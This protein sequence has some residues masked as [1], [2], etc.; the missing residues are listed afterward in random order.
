MER[1]H[2]FDF[3]RGIAI[4][5]VIGIHTCGKCGLEN[6]QEVSSL[7]AR[8]IIN[9]AVPLFLTLSGFLL[10]R[11]S[12]N[13]HEDCIRF[14]KKQIPKVYIPCLIWSLPLFIV[15]LINGRSL[16]RQ[17]FLLFSGGYSIYYFIPLIIQCYLLLPL[18]KRLSNVVLGVGSF[19]IT[20]CSAILISYH[21]GYEYPFLV[22]M[23]PI[24]TW[25]L[26][27]ALGI[28][29]CRSERN[30]RLS[31]LVMWII[32]SIVL[33]IVESLF[34]KNIGVPCPYDS[35]KPSSILYAA[36]LIILLFSKR[37]ELYYV[38]HRVKLIEYIGEISFTLYLGH[39]Y[40]IMV[41]SS[42]NLTIPFAVKWSTVLL[43]GT[44]CVYFL[45][46]L[47]VNKTLRYILGL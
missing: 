26:F 38:T 42:I 33:Q 16:I 14:W 20:L 39:C 9:V 7:L 41:L 25:I 8:E 45:R 46:K 3:L 15:G 13:S 1:N 29:L 43:L 35:T 36:I 23:A 17:S 28:I 34:Q 5:M 21:G 2:Y 22:Y 12:F 32:V 18:L 10:S 11:K 4:I 47:V 37:M 44:I 6:W 31:I 24:T 40:I 19:F 30:Y 27:F